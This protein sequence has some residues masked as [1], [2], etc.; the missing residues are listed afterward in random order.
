V[1]QSQGTQISRVP[2]D[3]G[4]ITCPSVPR[5]ASAAGTLSCLPAGEAY[6]V[7]K[8]YLSLLCASGAIISILLVGKCGKLRDPYFA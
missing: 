4:E 6:P 1:A 8:I 7:Q 5:P 2:L 3:I